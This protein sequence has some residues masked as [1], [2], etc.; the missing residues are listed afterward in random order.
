MIPFVLPGPL[1]AFRGKMFYWRNVLYYRLLVDSK[2]YADNMCVTRPRGPRVGGCPVCA[3]LVFLLLRRAPRAR[4]RGVA[5]PREPVPSAQFFFALL[6]LPPRA[7]AAPV[8][9]RPGPQPGPCSP[10]PFFSH[11]TSPRSRTLLH[12][13]QG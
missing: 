8:Y 13:P 6:L 2:G 10:L 4:A 11:S 7:V 9:G 12:A 5:A 1:Q 3:L